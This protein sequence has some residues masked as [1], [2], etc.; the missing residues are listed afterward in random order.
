MFLLLPRGLQ[1]I[2][3]L[4]YTWIWIG[5]AVL[6]YVPPIIAGTLLGHRLVGTEGKFI[7][8]YL[9]DVNQMM[10][11]LISLP[12]LL[13][14][15]LRE[16]RLLPEVLSE[17]TKDGTAAWQL[18]DAET[19][20]ERWERH[21][22]RL[23]RWS[24]P[25]GFFVSVIVFLLNYS[26]HMQIHG[27]MWLTAYVDSPGLNLLGWW[28]L[29]VQIGLF[30]FI[31]TLVVFRMIGG[32]ALLTSYARSV[33]ISV[34]PLHPDKVGGL[35]PVARLGLQNQTAV[36]I[37]GINVG[38]LFIV[39]QILGGGTV[40][41]LGF[42]AIIL[43]LII[44]PA[45]FVGPLIPFR[46]HLLRGKTDYLQTIANQFKRDLDEVL[47]RLEEDLETSRKLE[48][49]EHLSRVHDR[50]AALPEWPLDTSTI[51]RFGAALLTPG[52]SVLIAWIFKNIVEAV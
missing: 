44:A 52:L 9:H 12:A 10:L 39:L 48:K 3:L 1:S 33:G 46:P 50:V 22:Q 2:S 30:Y 7:L 26:F 18:T 19:F 37:V 15:Y 11:L 40:L 28:A 17:L 38:T 29:L 31:L 35:K 25:A 34:N 32:I 8:P 51:R 6:T 16:A 36:A 49:L 47:G 14:I 43:Y 20:V 21:Y 4:R 23:N 27:Q 41:W 24:V 5:V 13:V 45:V 42:L